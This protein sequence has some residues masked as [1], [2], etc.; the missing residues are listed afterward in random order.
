MIDADRHVLPVTGT[1]EA[2]FSFAQA[3]VQRDPQGLVVS[4]NPFYQIYEG[5]ALLAGVEPHYLACDESNGF[6]PDYASVPADTR[7]R[8]EL[9][10]MCS[11]GNPTGRSEERRV[12]LE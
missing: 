5:A 10:L 11:P 4:P 1:R 12:G 3:V 9:L 8:C 6:V 2:L 7:R